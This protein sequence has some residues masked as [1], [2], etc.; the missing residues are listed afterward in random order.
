MTEKEGGAPYRPG[1]DLPI[2]GDLYQLDTTGPSEERTNVAGQYSLR[3]SSANGTQTVGPFTAG[4]GAGNI[5][6]TIPASATEG[7]M[8]APENNFRTGVTVEVI[9][10]S[11]D[12]PASGEWASKI[13]GSFPV[14]L[15]SVPESLIVDNSFV[16]PT[17]WVKPGDTYSGHVDNYTDPR[18]TD[19]LWRFDFDCLTFDVLSMEG[20]GNGPGDGPGDLQDD[21]RFTR[22][23]GC[24]EFDYG[25]VQATTAAP[26]PAAAP[27]APAPAEAAKRSASLPATG[28]DVGHAWVA[29]GL[30]L[31]FAFL[32]RLA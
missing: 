23:P 15:E 10:A 24:A 17:G 31:G 26:P 30:L 13:A 21:V 28:S 11:Y 18:R 22:G 14:S 2:T 12:D 9:D 25:H 7:L 20:A 19:G 1:E 4:S 6:A 3:V 8:G 32:R 16:S 5:D 29:L 27:P